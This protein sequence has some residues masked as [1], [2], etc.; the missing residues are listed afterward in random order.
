MNLHCLW[1]RE[2]LDMDQKG[3]YKQENYRPLKELLRWFSNVYL[4]RESF[5]KRDF[6]QLYLYIPLVWVLLMD[7]QIPV[8]PWEFDYTENVSYFWFY[9][10]FLM[11]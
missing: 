7:S 6:A 2:G 11:Y 5:P 10:L 1:K 3:H 4:K 9:L 8:N